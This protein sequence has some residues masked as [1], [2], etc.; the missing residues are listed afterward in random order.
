MDSLIQKRKT[1]I[2][3]LVSPIVAL[4]LLASYKKYVSESGAEVRL[5][6]DGYD[7]RDILSGHYLV[8]RIDYGIA[9]ICE[10]RSRQGEAYACLEPKGFSY[11]KPESCKL[12]IQGSCH[13][14]RFE[15]GVEK[16]FVPEE[17]AKQLET[18]IRSET[19][20]IM[21]SIPLNGKAQVKDLLINGRPWDE[22]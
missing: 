14:G 13:Y 10:D 20:E 21:L 1:L 16:F 9:G 6:I 12:L 2:V 11:E 22:Q 7:P 19:A 8:Y 17:K 3:S 18:M 5:P 15:A 4:V